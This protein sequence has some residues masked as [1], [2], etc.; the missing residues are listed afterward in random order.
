MKITMLKEIEILSIRYSIHWDK[1]NDAGS[2]SM[3]NSLINIGIKNY[4]KDPLYTF[5]VLSHEIMEVILTMMGASY[6]NSRTRDNYL[7]NYDHQTYENAIQIF[8][9]TISKFIKQ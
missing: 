2:F 4:K 5:S 3:S 6:S 1:S 8:S 9:Q 7:F